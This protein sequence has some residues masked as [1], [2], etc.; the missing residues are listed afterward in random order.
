MCW[1]FIDIERS[2]SLLQILLILL[3][4]HP[5]GL[6]DGLPGTVFRCVDKTVKSSY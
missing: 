1:C 3:H 6:A 4:L 5:S 2:A